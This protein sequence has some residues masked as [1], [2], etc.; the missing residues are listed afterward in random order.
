MVSYFLLA[1]VFVY[2]YHESTAQSFPVRLTNGQNNTGRVEV[3]H[4]G[5][6]GGVCGIS[7][8]YRDATVVCRMFGYTKGTAVKRYATQD[9]AWY[10]WFGN[11]TEPSLVWMNGA[12][13]NGTE[14]SL[15]ECPF[16][17]FGNTTCP[18]Y[19]GRAYVFCYD[20]DGSDVEVR[21]VGGTYDASGHVEVHY[22]SYWGSVA[23]DGFY[24]SEAEVVC[25]M[26][27]YSHGISYGG[28]TISFTKLPIWMDY[29]DCNGNE[30]NIANCTFGGWGQI[31]SSLGIATALCY[32]E[33]LATDEQQGVRLRDG[34]SN[35]I[36]AVEI[37]YGGEWMMVCG[38]NWGSTEANIVCQ[39][40]GYRNGSEQI[41]A[42]F[43]WDSV[44]DIIPKVH[45]S[46]T[47][48]ESSIY[49]CTFSDVQSYC[50]YQYGRG[51]VNCSEP[52][53]LADSSVSPMTPTTETPFAL[54]LENGLYNN[55]GRLGVYHNGQWGGVCEYG[56]N[57]NDANVACRM[58]GYT[59]GTIT[60]QR[61]TLDSVWYE[62]FGN[63]TDPGLIWM[64]NVQC[65][66]T[67]TSLADCPFDGWGVSNCFNYKQPAYVF[68]YN[69][70]TSPMEVRIVNGK[71]DGYGH[72]EVHYSSIWG[73]VPYDGFYG[74]EAEVVCRTLGYR[75]GISYGGS[76]IKYSTIPRWM[77][78]RCTGTETNFAD[79]PIDGRDQ[80]SYDLG[81]ATAL[82]YNNTQGLNEQES[83]HL[84]DVDVRSS[85]A[86]EVVYGDQRVTVCG[87]N[88]GDTEAKIV[89][90]MLGFRNGTAKYFQRYQWESPEDLTLK[91]RINC[92]GTESSIYE[93]TFSNVS[94]YC[95]YRFGR[96]GVSCSEPIGNLTYICIFLHLG[97]IVI[98]F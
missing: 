11:Q 55:S 41:Y 14:N 5:Q 32:N 66:G 98:S 76:E 54:R 17:G 91:I 72:I 51:G 45:I 89:C 52:I 1:A 7:W 6:W 68:C 82:C 56:W 15:L 53:A 24:S 46:C 87:R 97:I 88:W 43:P 61:Y 86:V 4:D 16:G 3:Y 94:S 19:Y 57:Y 27:G 95:D 71:S 75:H 70:D 48:T 29:L 23:W 22:S 69:E 36:G 39:M 93:C 83:L 37:M 73:G 20:E 78:R 42:R 25:R 28:S 49:E 26:L 2:G 33:L 38:E 10:E 81:I 90:R 65:I 40:L 9:S 62:W 77:K 85:G 31:T 96:G 60:S 63:E 84:V 44:E 30:T 58:L 47:G 64:G 67:E 21:L 59:N 35:S 80:I 18:Q 13:C 92:S 12:Q 74:N 50:N 34:V 8:D 79:C